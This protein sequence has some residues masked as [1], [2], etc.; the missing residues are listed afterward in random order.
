M[1]EDERAERMKLIARRRS[2]ENS[3]AHRK[4]TIA[5]L[6]SKL[7]VATMNV[8]VAGAITEMPCTPEVHRTLRDHEV[9]VDERSATNDRESMK[10]VYT[11]L[12]HKEF[13]H[14]IKGRYSKT[15]RRE[16]EVFMTD[17]CEN[18]PN[19]ANHIKD[20]FGRKI[21][22]ET[23]DPLRLAT[24]CY[25]EIISRKVLTT[26]RDVYGEKEEEKKGHRN[27][28]LFCSAS[29]MC[30]EAAHAGKGAMEI[31]GGKIEL[32]EVGDKK[33]N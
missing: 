11:F 19:V 3:R 6:R 24:A 15:F 12:K 13:L 28:N 10:G 8:K 21:K 22:T 23:F 25:D 7:K 9:A 32:K 17:L 14:K 26:L 33:C 2:A 18:M 1:T 5:A 20:F 29:M 30:K 27:Q 16:F 31:L 4:R